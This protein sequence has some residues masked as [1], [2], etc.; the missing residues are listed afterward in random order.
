MENYFLNALHLEA[1]ANT[2]FR[3]KCKM[4]WKTTSLS[5]VPKRRD[6]HFYGPHSKTNIS[7]RNSNI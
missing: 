2:H 7:R 1:V 4:K 3:N 5:T 6:W